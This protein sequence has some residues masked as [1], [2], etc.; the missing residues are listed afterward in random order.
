MKCDGQRA[1]DRQEM[2]HEFKTALLVLAFP[3]EATHLGQVYTSG[4]A[5]FLGKRKGGRQGVT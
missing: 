4:T 2:S 5:L 1:L 3:E